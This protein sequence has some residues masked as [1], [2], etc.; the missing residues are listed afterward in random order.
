MFE[1]QKITL[2]FA[3]VILFFV[4]NSF[5]INETEW[6]NICSDADSGAN[7]GT[8]FSDSILISG[9]QD[10]FKGLCRQKE[11]SVG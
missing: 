9:D 7:P 6:N 5:A 4:L 2:V 1:N 8:V 3:L 11:K 10:W